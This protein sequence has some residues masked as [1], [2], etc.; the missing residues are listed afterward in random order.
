MPQNSWKLLFVFAVSLVGFSSFG[1][2]GLGDSS[3]SYGAPSSG[4]GAPS[5]S[6]GAASSSNGAPSSSYGTPASSYGAPAPSYGAPAPSSGYGAS[7]NNF[8][9]SGANSNNFG[10]SGTSNFGA[11]LA[12]PNNNGYGGAKVSDLY[13]LNAFQ[14]SDENIGNIDLTQSQQNDYIAQ[15]LSANNYNLNNVNN[16]NTN[17]ALLQQANAAGLN[18]QY[19]SYN[20]YLASASYQVTQRK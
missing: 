11:S 13:Y 20:P 18:V 2:F 6:Y 1:D 9:A 3:S 12:A 5:S 14:T 19:P 15:L 8:G 16:V 17:N 7:N 4:Y 10:T